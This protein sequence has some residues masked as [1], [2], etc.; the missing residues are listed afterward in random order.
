MKIRNIF[1]DQVFEAE[2][3][4]NNLCKELYWFIQPNILLDG[5]SVYW[6]H[7]KL[8]YSI[9][10]YIHLNMIEKQHIFFEKGWNIKSWI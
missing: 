6:Q 5:F 8:S 10:N 2:L 1:N 7:E 4:F 3:S 9:E